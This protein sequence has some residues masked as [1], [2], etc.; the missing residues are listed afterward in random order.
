[1]INVP[2]GVA[3]IW[4]TIRHA[5]ETTQ[6]RER[7]I[8]VPGLSIAIVGLVAL[9]AATVDAGRRGFAHPLV[10]AGFGLAAAATIGFV[11]VEARGN[12]GHMRPH[13]QPMLPLT[14]FRSRTFSAMSVIGL[15]V[16][17]AFYGLIFVLSLYFQTTL[18]Y[19]PLATGL[20]FA[21]AT[22]AVFVANLVA[23][24][25]T[26]RFGTRPVMAAAA[27]LMAASLAGLLASTATTAFSP[28]AV[29][30]AGLGFGIGTIV[31]IMT[32]ALLGSV[33]KSRSGVASG[34]LNSARQTGSALGV[35]LFG[36]LAA[37]GL[38]S[39]LR[40][41]LIISIAIA[42][43]IAGLA[44]IVDPEPGWAGARRQERA[45]STAS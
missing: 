12:P 16:N 18:H 20:A 8:D 5:T 17:I 25:L 6:S 44:T 15:I 4:L 32:A 40:L 43:V 29:G 26:A 10:L 41:A 37:A 35:A 3:A 14:L 36:S 39:G 13:A 21:P 30:L 7:G 22:A 31:P 34:T 1:L 45:L 23:G 38:T 11:L 2:L 42:G 27:V 9:T 19:S 28:M 33:E 24:R